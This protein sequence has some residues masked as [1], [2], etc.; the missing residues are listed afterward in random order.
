MPIQGF[1]RY[2]DYPYTGLQEISRLSLYRASRDIKTTP[3]QGF[4]R[5]QDYMYIG[6]EKI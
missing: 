2:Q 6:H 1:K 5:Y 4:K 3:I